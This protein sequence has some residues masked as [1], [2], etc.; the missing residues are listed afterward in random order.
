MPAIDKAATDY[1]RFFKTGK[2]EVCENAA[3][4]AIGKATT[5]FSRQDR[6]KSV[7]RQFGDA[8]N[9]Q[10]SDSFQEQDQFSDADNWKRSNNFFSGLRF[11]PKFTMPPL[12][13]CNL[14]AECP[15]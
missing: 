1:D 13:G 10:G 2:H 14:I 6:I 5:D 7:Q 3:M 4:P 15:P 11:L 12:A 8:G 9:W